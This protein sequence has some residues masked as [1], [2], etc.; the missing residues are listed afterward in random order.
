[1]KRVASTSQSD[2]SKPRAFSNRAGG[3]LRRLKLDANKMVDSLII[4]NG[5]NCN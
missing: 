3:K 1:M 4:E 2:P 5:K